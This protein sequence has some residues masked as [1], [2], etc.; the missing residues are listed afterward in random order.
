MWSHSPHVHTCH[1]NS[2]NGNVLKN[3]TQIEGMKAHFIILCCCDFCDYCLGLLH[4][5]K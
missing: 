4:A 2:N 3:I 1:G 5:C